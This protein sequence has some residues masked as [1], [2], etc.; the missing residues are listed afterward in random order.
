MF[1][2]RSFFGFTDLF[3]GRV[4]HG[5]SGP[6][7]PTSELL[8]VSGQTPEQTP[9]AGRRPRNSAGGTPAAR[10]TDATSPGGLSPPSPTLWVHTASMLGDGLEK[11][12]SDPLPSPARP[13][14]E[15][16]PHVEHR[17]SGTRDHSWPSTS[18]HRGVTC[19][20]SRPLGIQQVGDMD[21]AGTGQLQLEPKPPRLLGHQ[22]EAVTQASR[23]PHTEAHGAPAGRCHRTPGLPRSTGLPV[24][25]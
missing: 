23:W 9:R 7:P 13:P 6:A 10:R 22:R 24:Q 15:G 1:H 19:V 16:H 20:A 2:L 12:G 4:S 25:G 3:P 5:R 8:W 11:A 14:G 21:A 18:E 17:G